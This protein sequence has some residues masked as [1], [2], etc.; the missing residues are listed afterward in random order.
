ALLVSGNGA[1]ISV[2]VTTREEIVRI[3]PVNIA[4]SLTDEQIRAVRTFSAISDSQRAPAAI[5]QLLVYRVRNPG[6]S[7]V[8][9]RVTYIGA[10]CNAARL[11]RIT[12]L[13]GIVTNRGTVLTNFPKNS[14][15]NSVAIVS[16]DAN[17][18]SNLS[19]GFHDELL[20]ANTIR[21]YKEAIYIAAGQGLEFQIGDT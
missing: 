19:V 6:G 1:N 14:L 21:E 20:V 16:V 15:A 5:N 2:I 9:V 10:L 17:V 7:G 18:I 11:F 3:E 13:Q 12:S 8:V 4:V